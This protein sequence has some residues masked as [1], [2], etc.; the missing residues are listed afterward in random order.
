MT[1]PD[2]RARDGPPGFLDG[3]EPV[4]GASFPMTAKVAATVLLVALVVLAVLNRDVVA[5][6]DFGWGGTAFGAALAAT[7]LAGWWSILTSRTSFD[8][9][10]IRQTGLFTKEV[11][12]ADVKRLKL[13]HVPGLEAV[14]IPRLVVRGTGI[15]VVT[16]Q[17][18]DPQVLAAFRRLAYG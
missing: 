5:G 13:V 16:F 8:G 6:V 3:F 17:T 12:L 14:L 2:D 9:T 11:A 10:V 7:L 4:E 1:T 18:A 15:V